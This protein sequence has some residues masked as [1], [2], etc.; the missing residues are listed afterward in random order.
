MKN[1]FKK[2]LIKALRVVNNNIDKTLFLQALMIERSAPNKIT[3]L[4]V[5]EFSVF[6]Q[7]GEDGILSWIFSKI[8]SAPK[9]FIEFGVQNYQES[10]TRYLLQTKNWRGL[11]IDSSLKNV[12]E[13]KNS[14]F[15]WRHDLTAECVFIDKDN[16]NDIFHRQLHGESEIGLLSIDI[17]GNDYW[18]WD[19]IDSIKPYVVVCEYNAVFGDIHPISVPYKREFNRTDE[20]FSNLYFG[21]SIAALKKLAIKK[22]YS[23][24]GTCSN[25][26]NAFFVRNDLYANF[27]D[28]LE[29]HLSFPSLTR[30][31]R[32]K[33]G[34]L[35]YLSGSDRKEIISDMKVFNLDT[36]KTQKISDIENLYSTQW[37]KGAASE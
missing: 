29:H 15:F 31:S 22:G 14:Q 18:I 11:V 2:W 24:L 33:S 12:Q 20:H 25:G 13:I 3:S 9:I 21:C 32:S 35:T 28:K 4:D 36:D 19:A 7:W 30:E 27:D 10:N 26:V 1:F 8:P 16:V 17:D 37:I 34:Q 23:F 6:S 5:V